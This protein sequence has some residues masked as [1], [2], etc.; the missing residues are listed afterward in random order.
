[1]EDVLDLIAR[2]PEVVSL[3]YRINYKDGRMQPART[4]LD[5]GASFA[6]ML[7]FDNEAFDD[8]MRLYL[9]IHTDHEGGNVSA[10]T[11][12]LVGSAL[13]DPYL[14]FAAALNG[15][16]GPLHGLANQEVLRWIM[17]LEAE[18]KSKNMPVNEE[19][20]REYVD[21]CSRVCHVVTHCSVLRC[22]S[23]HSLLI[24][25]YPPL[26]LSDQVRV[27]DAQSW[28]C[29]PRLWPRCTAAPRSALHVSAG[30]RVEAHARR[31]SVQDCKVR[32]VKVQHEVIHVSLSLS[33]CVCVDS[34]EL[35]S[36]THM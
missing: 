5:Y 10:H 29:H 33:V 4:D 23:H 26:T 7:G 19:T 6:H 17:E 32:S 11:T 27:V 34:V 28:P 18:F 24:Y 8:L 36:F 25:S 3:I 13:S 20:I 35:P 12:R 16:A 31:P 9:I 1:L 15:L 22:L 2:L 14:S 30:V 21:K